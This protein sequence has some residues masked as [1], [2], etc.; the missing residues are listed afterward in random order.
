[1]KTGRLVAI[2]IFALLAFAAAAGGQPLRGPNGFY[3]QDCTIPAGQ[4]VRG[5]PRRDSIPA[6]T[7]P[8]LLP[9]RANFFLRPDD[10]VI[11]VAVTD[12]ARAY[13][14]QI[15]VW[16]EVVNDMLGGR[17]IAVTDCPL[18]HSAITFD[19]LAGGQVREFGVSGLLWNSNLLIYDRRPF[20]LPE[21]LWS[22]AA[23][24]A[25]CGPEARRGT[26]LTPLASE[27]VSW[28]NWRTRYPETTV[29]SPQTGYRRNYAYNPYAEYFASEWLMFPITATPE[30][31]APRPPKERMLVVRVGGS[32]KAYAMSDVA[33]AAGED[34][35]FT[36]SIGDSAVKFT[37]D[38]QSNHA[39]A[40]PAE[41]TDEDT[42]FGTAYMFWFAWRSIYPNG[43]VY[44]IP[45]TA[46]DKNGE[47]TDGQEE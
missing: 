42:V 20:G 38:R 17:P 40:E 3:L 41:S 33:E 31:L 12:E 28:E 44:S 29:I 21:S 2:T 32:V 10:P 27:L 4:I 16:H 15:L 22:Q 1:M 24:K 39:R 26:E 9:A 23:M 18:C 8:R 13:P 6:L 7:R 5:G 30:D 14:L 46:E 37:Y 45:E 35:T 47:G 34:D 11:G 43:E 25:V 19:R 36:D